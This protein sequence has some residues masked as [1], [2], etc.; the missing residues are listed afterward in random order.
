MELQESMLFL[1]G[2]ITFQWLTELV[3]IQT[4]KEVLQN[5]IHFHF[6]QRFMEIWWRITTSKDMVE[7]VVDMGQWESQAVL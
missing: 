1:I 2:L 5:F 3:L 7:Y 6:L 4:S